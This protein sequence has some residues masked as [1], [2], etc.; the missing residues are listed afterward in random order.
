ME[1]FSCAL[2]I[3]DNYVLVVTVKKRGLTRLTNHPVPKVQFLKKNRGL[4]SLFTLS[5]IQEENKY[6]K[7][8]QTILSLVELH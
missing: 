4:A 6:L 5:L 2:N 3:P 7:V 8:K 1:D